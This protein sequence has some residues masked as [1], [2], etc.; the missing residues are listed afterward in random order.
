MVFIVTV[1]QCTSIFIAIEKLGFHDP[2]LLLPFALLC[3]NK[4]TSLISTNEVNKPVVWLGNSILS[5]KRVLDADKSFL[6]N[7]KSLVGDEFC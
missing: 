5:D 2:S 4:H 7:S 1:K 3:H 6:Q